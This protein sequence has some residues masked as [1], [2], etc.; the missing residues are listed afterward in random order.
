MIS[1]PYKAC[2]IILPKSSLLK[3]YQLL[4]DYK[5]IMFTLRTI[6][7]RYGDILEKDSLILKAKNELYS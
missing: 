1:V 2:L 3:C 5:L 6:W 7:V 4:Y